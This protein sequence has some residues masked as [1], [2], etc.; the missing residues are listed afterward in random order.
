MFT[1]SVS[2]GY[3]LSFPNAFERW[4]RL[5]LARKLAK[6]ARDDANLTSLILQRV[7]EE[8][9]FA[10][11]LPELE[12][13]YLILASLATSEALLLLEV[14]HDDAEGP[15]RQLAGLCLAEAG[16]V[17]GLDD[18]VVAAQ[19]SVV[20]LRLHAARAA[21]GLC[22]E[23][24]RGVLAVLAEDRHPLVKD[25]AVRAAEICPPIS[26][27]EVDRVGPGSTE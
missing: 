10:H 26:R 17:A 5:L 24:S 19:S 11:R 6:W 13:I 7:E 21:A 14:L 16:I 15:A 2:S 12:A 22:D 8:L 9:G 3:C 20:R 25:A 23:T 1:I 27:G 18:V 4:Q